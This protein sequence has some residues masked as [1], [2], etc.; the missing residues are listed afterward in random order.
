MERKKWNNKKDWGG[1]EPIFGF[2]NAGG[3]Q[4][5]IKKRL[6]LKGKRPN[7]FIEIDSI[8]EY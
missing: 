8:T 6:L 1:I 4:A 5:Q 3:Q 7:L 2:S